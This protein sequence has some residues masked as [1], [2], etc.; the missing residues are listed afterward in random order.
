MRKGTKAQ[1]KPPKPVE[2]LLR[3]IR[4]VRS[5]RHSQKLEELSESELLIYM[6]DI[7]SDDPHER[8]LIACALAADFARG[9]DDNN[10]DKACELLEDM[11]VSGFEP[12][13]LIA[14]RASPVFREFQQV[15]RD[16]P[17]NGFDYDRDYEEIAERFERI[18]A[19]AIAAGSIAVQTQA[20]RW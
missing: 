11:G 4:Q 14:M 12:E 3:T 5:A 15:E 18:R 7:L 20:T 9:P 19:L 10:V 8:R 6:A 17:P 16:Y 13:G 2:G 1:S